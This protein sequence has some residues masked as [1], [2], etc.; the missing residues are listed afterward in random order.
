MTATSGRTQLCEAPQVT[1]PAAQ[2]ASSND[3]GNG[4]MIIEASRGGDESTKP[5]AFS[6]TTGTS[7][8]AQ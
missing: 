5:E 6:D 4:P 3:L 2:A 8:G 1:T 7:I